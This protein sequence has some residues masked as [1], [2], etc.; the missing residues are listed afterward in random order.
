MIKYSIINGTEKVE[1]TAL[2]I[3]EKDIGSTS[4]KDQGYIYVPK[5][6]IGKKAKV[7]ILE[8]DDDES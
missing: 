1:G 6:F 8:G 4:R 5:E 7:L 3:L 2:D